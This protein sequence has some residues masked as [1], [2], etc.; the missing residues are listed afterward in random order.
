MRAVSAPLGVI[1]GVLIAIIL[2]IL[3]SLVA[4][5]TAKEAVK[6]QEGQLMIVDTPI[7][8][9]N[10][11]EDEITKIIA[12]IQNPSSKNISLTGIELKGSTIYLKN[13]VIIPPRERV[14]LTF[15]DNRRGTRLKLNV[16]FENGTVKTYKSPRG[17][18]LAIV[19]QGKVSDDVENGY[20][21][22][23]LL[24]DRGAFKVYARIEV[25]G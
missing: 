19:T 25:M 18:S 8:F 4:F 9:Y 5:N 15:Y 14:L 23:H 7:A 2:V 3:A 13:P 12:V 21:E 11:S 16:T 17:Y 10:Q 20:I 1:F 6:S 22:F 24:T